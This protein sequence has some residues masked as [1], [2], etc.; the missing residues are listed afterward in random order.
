M[1]FSGKRLIPILINISQMTQ[2]AQA[3][4]DVFKRVQ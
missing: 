4:T 1:T 2:N 3:G